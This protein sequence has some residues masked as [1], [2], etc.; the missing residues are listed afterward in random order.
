MLYEVIT[1]NDELTFYT[2][3]GDYI[4]R[5]SLFVSALLLMLIVVK[6]FR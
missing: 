4:A 3:N 1:A 2:K 5:I 6:R